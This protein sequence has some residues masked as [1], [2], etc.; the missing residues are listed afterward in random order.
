M[1]SLSPQQGSLR[2]RNS[3]Q[4]GAA[5]FPVGSYDTFRTA[6]PIVSQESVVDATSLGH[7]G[8]LILLVLV[9]S[10]THG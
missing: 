6:G 5:G 9:L 4:D 3:P 2:L 8:R 7:A 1:L 10:A